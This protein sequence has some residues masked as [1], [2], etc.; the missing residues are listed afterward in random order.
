[1]MK[2]LIVAV[3][4][5]VLMLMIS[6]PVGNAQQ[7]DRARLDQLEQLFKPDIPRVM[8]LD[9]R[10]TTGGQPTD[11]AYAK[12]AASGFHSVL[13]LRSGNEGVDLFRERAVVEKSDLRYFN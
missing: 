2:H 12:A 9:E 6:F 3:P 7:S 13:S 4:L 1:M 11:Q 8:C 5:V 10:F